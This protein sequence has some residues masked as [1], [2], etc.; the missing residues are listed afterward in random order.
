M[1]GIKKIMNKKDIAEIKK[2]FSKSGATF[3]KISGCYVN[4]DK[5][6]ILNFTET[7]LNLDDEEFY[8]Y[9]E[10]AKKVLSGT[11]GNNLLNLE[12]PLEEEKEGGK[13]RFL[14]GLKESKLKNEG[15]LDTFFHLIIEN[16]RMVGNYLILVFHDNYDVLTKTSDNNKLDESE[17]VYEY[18]LC[19]MCPVE[20]AS[21][22]LSYKEEENRIGKRDRDWIV[23]APE[24]GFVF[25]AFT[26]RSTDVHSLLLYT[27]N[28]LALQEELIQEAL[29][30]SIKPTANQQKNI[31]EN[32]VKANTKE[33]DEVYSKIQENLYL[34]S[35]EKEQ[36]EVEDIVITVNEVKE[37]L[38][39]IELEEEVSK[40]ITDSFVES[41]EENKPFVDYLIDKKIVAENEKKRTQRAL[42]QKVSE[43]EKEL[44]DTKKDKLGDYDV[45]LHISKEK[46]EKVYSQIINGQK[47]VVIPLEE[48]E[49][50]N[51]VIIDKEN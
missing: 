34:L 13:Q 21:P 49:E 46:S 25:P 5:E 16:Y 14:Q 11:Y 50:I 31:F 47:C 45:V 28:T 6:I 15:L 12:F 27:K 23:K 40:K 2:R 43:L 41:L 4:A 17:E 48:D 3:T 9:L 24:N 35:E 29:G 32:I 8:K 33:E 39:D 10:I 7:F 44:I 30:C 36:N 38:E 42:T 19:A 37:I 20:L 18:L 51:K 1:K 26:D 22:A